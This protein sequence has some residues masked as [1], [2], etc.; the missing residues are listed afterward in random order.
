MQRRTRT[1]VP[2]SRAI[3]S[4]K[5]CH[6]SSSRKST[7]SHWVWESI[8]LAAL[9]CSSHSTRFQLCRPAMARQIL[10]HPPLR[11][12]QMQRLWCCF[13]AT[14]PLHAKTNINSTLLG[15]GDQTTRYVT[16]SSLPAFLDSC[17]RNEP[18]AEP[19]WACARG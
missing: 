3:S 2:S 5:S 18:A 8:K 7:G 15:S 12:G 4:S 9:R 19:N 1:K 13:L 16:T 11:P 10:R 6:A 14:G 17:H